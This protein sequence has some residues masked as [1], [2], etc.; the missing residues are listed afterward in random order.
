MVNPFDGLVLAQLLGGAAV[1]GAAFWYF[2]PVLQGQLTLAQFI[3][4]RLHRRAQRAKW[5]AHAAD[6]ALVAYAD[7]KAKDNTR[8]VS[9]PAMEAGQ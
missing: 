7:I 4:M 6:Q 1:L 3:V 8:P 9:V 5:T 2:L